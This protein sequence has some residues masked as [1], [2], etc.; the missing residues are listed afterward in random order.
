MVCKLMLPHGCMPQAG[1]AAML[2][3]AGVDV[4]GMRLDPVHVIDAGV[5]ACRR[6]ESGVN[7]CDRQFLE[8]RTAT[9]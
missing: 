1:C 4:I 9:S 7:A 6:Q 5:S 2:S 8:H 3:E